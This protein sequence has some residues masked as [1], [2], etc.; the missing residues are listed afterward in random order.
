MERVTRTFKLDADSADLLLQ[1]AGSPRK[2]GEYL[3][4]VIR[5]LAEG[6]TVEARIRALQA[7]LDRLKAEVVPRPDG[8]QHG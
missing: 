8:E 6:Q 2:Q 7:E 4:A 5:R 3:S 1:L